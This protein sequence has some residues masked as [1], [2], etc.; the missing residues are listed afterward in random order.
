[1]GG[2]QGAESPSL[3]PPGVKLPAS[4][5]P[6]HESAQTRLTE[7]PRDNG[8]LERVLSG[9]PVVRLR[10]SEKEP[11]LL[12]ETIL[13][14]SRTGFPPPGPC[15]AAA[16][17]WVGLGTPDPEAAGCRGPRVPGVA[18]VRVTDALRPVAPPAGERGGLG[19]GRASRWGI[20][21]L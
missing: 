17:R 11:M 2:F 5:A 16:G 6:G 9:L 3:W 19:R 8:E 12:P 21:A 10:A 7:L 13:Q 20:L 18:A 4:A 15:R 14:M 1:M